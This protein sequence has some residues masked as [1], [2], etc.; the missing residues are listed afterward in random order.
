M[1]ELR[2]LP[3]YV[4]EHRFRRPQIKGCLSKLGLRVCSFEVKRIDQNF[5]FINTG[6]HVPYNLDKWNAYEHANSYTI[7]G[8]YQFWCQMAA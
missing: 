7:I 4:L 5:K 8:M 2:D 6:I 1:S 3:F